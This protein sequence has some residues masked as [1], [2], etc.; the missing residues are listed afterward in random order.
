MP[1]IHDTNTINSYLPAALVGSHI[2]T[3]GFASTFAIQSIYRSYVA[4]PASSGTRHREPLRKGYVTTFSFL[5]LL[6]LFVVGFFG[7]R[8]GSLSYR[9]WAAERG[10]ELP[11]TFFGDKG[12]LRGGEHPG[13]LHVVRWLNDT[14]IFRDAYEIVAEKA[15][16]F[17]WGQ[18]ISLGL[19][20]WS[21]YLA[22][23]GQR[24][25]ISHLWAFLVLAQQSSLSY[26][27][28][29][30]FIAILLTPVPLP[31]NVRDLTRTSVPAT[32]SR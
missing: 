18:Q 23:E 31:E 24:R 9:V 17:W 6:S 7:A 10:V 28:N 19:V 12:A 16:H 21:M 27:Q 22:I 3:I 4:L 13:R 26:A 30:F 1:I 11:E 15:R 32:S 20:S 8:F 25:N 29:L 2:F 14:P 5:A